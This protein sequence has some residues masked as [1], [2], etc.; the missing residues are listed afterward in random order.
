MSALKNAKPFVNKQIVTFQQ[1]SITAHRI[2][3]PVY[4]SPCTLAQ[5]R[6]LQ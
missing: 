6:G 3:V 4:A 5:R 1:V 2:T